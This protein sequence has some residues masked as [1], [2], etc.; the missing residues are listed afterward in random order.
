MPLRE[1]STG[2]R[3]RWRGPA[4]TSVLLILVAFL[5]GDLLPH[6]LPVLKWQRTFGG[7]GDDMGRSVRSTKDG[8]FVLVGWT[9]TSEDQDTFLVKTDP[10]GNLEWQMVLG[11]AGNDHGNDVQEMPDGGYIVVGS[12]GA[13]SRAG[14]DDLLLVRT[15]RR[16]DLVWQETHGGDGF[17]EGFSGVVTEGGGLLAPGHSNSFGEAFDVYLV[18]VSA[19]GDLEWQKTL[20]GQENEFAD[21]LYP[22]E[23]GI[24]LTGYRERGDYFTP[25][26][27]KLDISGNPGTETACPESIFGKEQAVKGLPDG[28]GGY[29]AAGASPGQGSSG[30]NSLRSVDSSC[31]LTHSVRFG[32]GRSVHFYP[33]LM[34]VQDGGFLLGGSVDE[35]GMGS[36]ESYMARIAPEEVSQKLYRGPREDGFSSVRQL[37]DGTFIAA[38]WTSSL[39]AGEWDLQLV[40]LGRMIPNRWFLRG[41]A[42]NDER[43]DISDAVFLL[44]GLFG[45][46]ATEL[47][48]LDAADTNDDGRLNMTDP[49][50]LCDAL[51]RGGPAIPRPRLQAGPDSTADELGCEE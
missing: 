17:E 49:V 39:G 32:F 50:F 22:A 31:T 14:F 37:A 33:S 41:D 29:T 9:E 13:T 51:F 2:V 38:G 36:S 20:G 28:G 25:F 44:Q 3:V 24:W 43:V 45:G 19:S 8:G 18:K 16:G 34:A 40:R 12:A 35:G 7:P 26:L 42:D 6:E 4:F 21:S 11:R 47:R 46:T 23:G 1:G 48:C 10:L 27:V 15:S 5:C 30:L